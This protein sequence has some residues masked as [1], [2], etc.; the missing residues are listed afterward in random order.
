MDNI[1]SVLFDHYADNTGDLFNTSNGYH[2]PIFGSQDL[3][4]DYNFNQSSYTPQYTNEEYRKR[5][6]TPTEF[7]KII[8][9]TT[10]AYLF[11]L[12]NN[13]GRWVPFKSINSIKNNIVWIYEKEH[14]AKPFKLDLGSN[15]D[16][17]QTQ[18]QEQITL[19][20]VNKKLDLILKLLN[21]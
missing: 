9:K 6:A 12:P 11:E 21:K 8:T 20:T 3:Y 14:L 1:E 7:I 17:K 5:F 15:E 18:Q 16:I 2:S 19:E 10:K 13:M 4:S